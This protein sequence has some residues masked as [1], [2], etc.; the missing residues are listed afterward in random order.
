MKFI[1]VALALAAVASAQIQLSDPTEG[2]VWKVGVPQYVR[3]TGN[4]AAMGAAGKA[5][6]VEIV[7]G[8]SGNVKFVADLG[9]I[10]C[11]SATNTSTTLTVPTKTNN[12]PFESG[13]YALRVNADPI[14]YTTN[15]IINNPEAPSTAPPAVTTPPSTEP[16][17]KPSLGLDFGGPTY[18]STQ[19]SNGKGWYEWMKEIERG[20]TTRDGTDDCNK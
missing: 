14:Q 12:G 15:F 5:V 2:T 8:P 6:K 11:T 7:N 20:S 9:T 10:D 3:W 1:A 4:C 17:T 16:S 13:T 19:T 18:F